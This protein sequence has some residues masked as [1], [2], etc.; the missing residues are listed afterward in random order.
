MHP[1]GTIYKVTGKNNHMKKHLS[2]TNKNKIHPTLFSDLMEF[3][4]DIN[5]GYGYTENYQKEIKEK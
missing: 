3:R 1:Y 4:L 2:Q 5:S